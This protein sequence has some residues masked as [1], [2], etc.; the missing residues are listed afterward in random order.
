M[1]AQTRIASIFAATGIVL[2]GAFSATAAGQKEPRPDAADQSDSGLEN[3]SFVV[4]AVGRESPISSF[5]SVRV[6]FGPPTL[7]HSSLAWHAKCDVFSYRVRIAA[8]RLMVSNGVS[9]LV[10]CP[11]RQVQE[12]AW[13]DDFFESDPRWHLSHGRLKLVAGKRVMLLKQE[14]RGRSCPG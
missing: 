3:K 1:K 10:G 2:L 11:K 6:S 5:R 7:L 12:D 8:R 9:T 4:V 14:K 13:L